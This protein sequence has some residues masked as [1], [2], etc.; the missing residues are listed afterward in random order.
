MLLICTEKVKTAPDFVCES[1]LR[2]NE[3]LQYRKII[4]FKNKVKA[5]REIFRQIKHN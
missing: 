4:T 3:D 1:G 5:F 2:M